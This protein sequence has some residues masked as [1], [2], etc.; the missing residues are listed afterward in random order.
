MEQCFVETL[1]KFWNKN[2]IESG[3]SRSQRFIK[4]GLLQNNCKQ[5][6]DSEAAVK[7]CGL[8][9]Q[10]QFGRL[11]YWALPQ[12]KLGG[13]KGKLAKEEEEVDTIREMNFQLLVEDS[14]LEDRA[15]PNPAETQELIAGTKQLEFLVRA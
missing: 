1:S 11:D 6:D 4:A 8:E 3:S 5:G 15:K 7:E 2:Q 10:W 14:N 13:A 12:V 9:H